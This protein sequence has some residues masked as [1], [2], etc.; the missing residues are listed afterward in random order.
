M[1][2]K[3]GTLSILN[4]RGVCWNIVRLCLT[5]TLHY[6]PSSQPAT[7]TVVSMLQLFTAEEP[8]RFLLLLTPSYSSLSLSVSVLPPIFAYWTPVI[9][10]PSSPSKQSPTLQHGLFLKVFTKWHYISFALQGI[11]PSSQQCSKFRETRTL[12]AQPF[13]MFRNQKKMENSLHLTWVSLFVQGEQQ[14]TKHH[15]LST[16]YVYYCTLKAAQAVSQL[17]SRII[18]IL[19]AVKISKVPYKVKGYENRKWECH[20]KVT[21]SFHCL[22]WWYFWLG[23]RVRTLFMN[24]D[25]FIRFSLGFIQQKYEQSGIETLNA[26][27]LTFFL[28]GRNNGL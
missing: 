1:A 8:W 22:N 11:F 2:R 9:S 13:G 5:N 18:H 10:L 15:F 20:I 7:V 12:H 14:C 23:I 24:I 21:I 4:A 17:S 26:L 25:I 6:T 16:L 3:H 19:K 28:W 27:V